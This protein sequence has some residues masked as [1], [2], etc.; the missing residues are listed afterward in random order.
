MFAQELAEHDF[1]L[2]RRVEV[3]DDLD[4]IARCNT[5]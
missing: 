4:K 2:A 5:A 3:E 1:R